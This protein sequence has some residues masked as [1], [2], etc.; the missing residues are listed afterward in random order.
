MLRGERLG[1]AVDL[2]PW[3]RFTAICARLAAPVAIGFDPPGQH[4]GAAF[5][6]AVRH[7]ADAH[8]LYPNIPIKQMT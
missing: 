8:E 1:V 6:I 5:D 3:A 4:R 7:C 2:T